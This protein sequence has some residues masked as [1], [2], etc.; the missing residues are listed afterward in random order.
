MSTV[1]FIHALINITF[2]IQNANFEHIFKNL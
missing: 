2:V 1:K